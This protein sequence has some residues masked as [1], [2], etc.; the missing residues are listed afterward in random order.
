ME[1]AFIEIK[2]NRPKFSHTTSYL[3]TLR[4]LTP[5][6]HWLLRRPVNITRRLPTFTP[7]NFII[8][9]VWWCSWRLRRRRRQKSPCTKILFPAPHIIVGSY[10]P[11]CTIVFSIFLTSSW[12]SVTASSTGLGIG[13]PGR[14]EDCAFDQLWTVI[15]VIR[16][17]K[18][19]NTAPYGNGACLCE[20]AAWF[21]KD[22][23]HL[24]RF[25]DRLRAMVVADSLLMII[26]LLTITVRSVN[27]TRIA[28]GDVLHVTAYDATMGHDGCCW[29]T[30]SRL[31]VLEWQDLL[32]PRW[33]MHRP[34]SSS[35]CIL[36]DGTHVTWRWLT[37]VHAVRFV[38]SIL[39]SPMRQLAVWHTVG[40]IWL[41]SI[42]WEYVGSPC[43]N[44]IT[45]SIRKQSDSSI[46]S[47]L[48]V[49]ITSSI[50]S[51]TK[52]TALDS[53][54]L[55]RMKRVCKETDTI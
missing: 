5:R 33:Y 39:Y 53:N 7:P 21:H 54:C 15:I 46:D 10:L 6:L 50:K 36:V 42:F 20:C 51:E 17:E 19:K 43:L 23:D 4:K 49:I 22:S 16:K 13:T 38:D 41:I 45:H 18:K 35:L 28:D 47:V 27:Q 3:V 37:K 30:T 40:R 1:V 31:R 44:N 2:M 34:S 14:I 32:H 25:A 48:F 9:F 8:H 12:F 11:F 55:S 29:W 26:D 24:R 52:Q